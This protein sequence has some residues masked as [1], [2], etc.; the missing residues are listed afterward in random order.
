MRAQIRHITEYQYPQPAWDSFNQVR[1]QPC[2]DEYQSLLSFRLNLEP[3]VATTS[4][5]DYFGTAV[6]HFH[7]LD[8]HST[9]KIETNSIVVK[10][11]KPFPNSA[12]ASGLE[13]HRTTLYEYLASSK[14]VSLETDW[15]ALLEYVPLLPQDDLLEYLMGLNAHLKNRFTY[16]TGVTSVQT[17]LEDF[18]QHGAGVCQ[19]F[20]HAMLGVCRSQGIPARYVS[21]YVY[22]GQDFLG[23]E[24]THA[25][26]EAFIPDTGWIGLDPTNNV[27]ETENHIRIGYGRDYDDIPPLHGLRRGGGLETLAVAVTINAQQQ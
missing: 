12:V 9:L 17:P 18:V 27:L 11:P 16:Q 6:Q 5:T 22:A 10:H 4:N 13:A 3:S 21:G 8:K 26:L 2:H 19:D 15:A 20:V 14:R 7:I 25:W 23:A 1:L 24:G